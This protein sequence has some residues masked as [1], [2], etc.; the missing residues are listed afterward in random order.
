MQTAQNTLTAQQNEFLQV[1]G[2]VKMPR[3]ISVKGYTNAHGDLTDYVVNIN[4]KHSNKVKKDVGQLRSLLAELVETVDVEP[5]KIQAAKELLDAFKK[6]A[7]PE[8]A[9]NQSIAQKEAYTHITGNI[10]RHNGTGVY[11][12]FA[13]CQSKKVHYRAERKPVNSRPLTIEKDKIRKT[14]RT[15]KY[16]TFPIDFKSFSVGVNGN[17]LE[18]VAK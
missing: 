10:K 14:L 5:L 15:S 3:Y 16:V 7:N 6:N 1:I 2:A 9:S 13:Y 8:T 11:Y 4:C 12:L 18:L 17:T